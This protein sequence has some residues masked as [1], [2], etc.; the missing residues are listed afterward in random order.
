[1]KKLLLVLLPFIFFINYSSSLIGQDSL[2]KKKDS[3]VSPV[4]NVSVNQKRAADSV[5]RANDSA[6]RAARA[7]DSV[8]RLEAIANSRRIIESVQQMLKTHRYF[9]FFAKPENRTIEERV[10]VN[11]DYLFYFL[12]GL[13][14][15]FTITKIIFGKYLNNLLTLFFRVTMRQQQLRDQL[16]QAPVASLFLNILFVISAGL[17][18]DFIAFYYKFTPFPDFWVTLLYC[19]GLIVVIYLA[20]LLILKLT[21]WIFNVSDATDT[22]IFI[23]FLVNK[24]IGMFLLPFLFL[25]AFPHPILFPIALTISYILIIALFSYRFIISYRPIRNEIKLGRFHFFIYLCAFEVA[26]LLLIYKV[27]LMFVERSF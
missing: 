9:Q 24:M 27:L 17:Y 20:K 8:N 12:C 13:V 18:L 3:V 2:S 4:Q 22:Y 15:Y 14:L 6:V 1:M 7:A 21:G 11:K 26:P 16:L 5:R 25:L 23:V 10:P 19:I